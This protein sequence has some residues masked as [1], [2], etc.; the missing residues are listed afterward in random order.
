[1]PYGLGPEDIQTLNINIAAGAG[2]DNTLVAAVAGK[3]VRVVSYLIQSGAATTI[4]MKSG[5][6]TTIATL[7]QTAAGRAAPF[8]GRIE[9]PAYETARGSA[10]VL[11]SSAAVQV[12]GHLAYVLV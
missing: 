6:G 3:K 11:N 8:S 5:A 2:A 12:T 10:L 4:S 9:A 1:M 7:D